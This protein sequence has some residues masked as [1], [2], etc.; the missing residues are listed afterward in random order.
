[1]KKIFFHLMLELKF[2]NAFSQISENEFEAQFQYL[3]TY[4]S[5]FKARN[6]DFYKILDDKTTLKDIEQFHKNLDP[7]LENIVII[8]IGGSALGFSSIY[9]AFSHHSE[10][11]F[12]VMDNVDPENIARM[13]QLDLKKTLF[14]VITKSGK[15]PETMAQ[16]LY[17]KEKVLNKKLDQRKHFVF[18]T[19]SNSFLNLFFL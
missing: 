6:Q 1:M 17:F 14:I 7:N 13:D 4:Q 2:T 12:F 19:E 10:K 8:G 9:Q 16:Y 15:T 3:E 5:Q 11:N 18:V